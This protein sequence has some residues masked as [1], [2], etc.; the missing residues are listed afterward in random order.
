VSANS[1]QAAEFGRATP[2]SQDTRDR[3]VAHWEQT[4]RAGVRQPDFEPA[5][6]PPL[7]L[8]HADR[9]EWFSRR[10]DGLRAQPLPKLSDAALDTLRHGPGSFDRRSEERRRPQRAQDANSAPG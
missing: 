5:D 10:A 8:T 1:E 4:L 7:G 6:G 9:K 3:T 2:E